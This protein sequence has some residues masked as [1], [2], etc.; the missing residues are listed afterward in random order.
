MDNLENRSAQEVKILKGLNK[1]QHEAVTTIN[2]PALVVAGAGSGKTRVLTHRIAY[3]IEHGIKPWNILALTFTNKAAQEMK[4]RIE[5]LAATGDASA[6][7]AGTFHSIFARILRRYAD[8]LGYTNNFSIYDSDDSLSL[9]KNVMNRLNINHKDYPPNGVRGRISAAK[10]KMVGAKEYSDMAQTL[11]EK[12]TGLIFREYEADM[13]KNNAMDFDDLLLNMIILLRE[14][15]DVLKSLQDQFHYILVDEYQDT[16]RAQY[17]AVKMLAKARQNLFVVGDDAQ[18]IYGWRGADIQNILDFKKDYPYSK[19]IRLE[20]NYRSTK[21]ILAAADGVIRNNRNQIPKKLWTDNPEGEK[22]GL[23]TAQDDRDE[24][25]KVAQKIHDKIAAGFKLKDFAILYRTNAQSLEIENTMRRYNFPYVVVGGTS[26][27]KRKEIKDTIAYLKLLVNPQDSESLLRIVNEPPRGIGATTLRAVRDFAAFRRVSLFE[28]FGRANEIGDLQARAQKL[29]LAFYNFITSMM[30][31]AMN[32]PPEELVYKYIEETG[33]TEMYREIN[34][35]ESLDRWNN[36]Q[37]LISDMKFY[38]KSNPEYT[39]ADYL[40]QIS[41][42]ADI[43]EKNTS[44]DKITLMT[45]HSAKGLEFPM[46]FIT[47]LE[48][49]LFPLSKS[50]TSAEEE[51]EERRLFYVGITRAREQLFLSYAQRRARF[52]EFT[53]QVPSRFLREIDRSL[54]SLSSG[55]LLPSVAASPAQSR[56][57]QKPSRPMDNHSYSQ[58]PHEE[59]YSQ[60]EMHGDDFNVGDNVKHAMFG[61]GKIMGLSGT[62]SKRTAVVLFSSVGRKQLLLQYAKLV[63]I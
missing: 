33:L 18:S 8:K 45:L 56:M 54:F 46:V 12:Q 15:S 53:N 49:G 6:I 30:Q 61:A 59:S 57:P 13:L 10:N 42:V 1:E 24:A 25:L 21:I 60:I 26:F 52:G 4:E 16:N 9:I 43:D 35:D 5:K 41:L 29:S 31:E 37:Q 22:I 63:K 28:A 58:I 34:T 44:E 19:V 14:F 55:A 3:M 7:W 48:R 17:I 50:D 11:L 27:Y 40:Q 20:Q 38:F 39:L 23:I 47:G 36:I 32:M 51:E 62:G 2:G